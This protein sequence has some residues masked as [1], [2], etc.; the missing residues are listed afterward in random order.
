MNV[1]DAAGSVHYESRHMRDD[2]QQVFNT[3]VE[4]ARNG[5]FDGAEEVASDFPF[6]ADFTP[7]I[8]LTPVREEVAE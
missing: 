5:N 7:V 3:V 2:Q 1:L 6:D 8:S 4:F